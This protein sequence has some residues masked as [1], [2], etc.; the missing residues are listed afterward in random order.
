[1]QPMFGKSERDLLTQ[2]EA[3]VDGVVRVE[4]RPGRTAICHGISGPR[5][6]DGGFL[7]KFE[8]V[9]RAIA[10]CGHDLQKARR[11]G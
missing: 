9:A 2:I 1:M 3:A 10:R 6:R 5:D 11:P 4:L 7:S 8:L